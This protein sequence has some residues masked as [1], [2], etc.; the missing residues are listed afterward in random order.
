VGGVQ[1]NWHVGDL[2]IDGDPLAAIAGLPF[3][4]EVI[5]LT[6]TTAELNAE[7]AALVERE[8]R[9]ATRHPERGCDLKW[10][11]DHI[12]M[13]PEGTLS[14][15]NCP[16]YAAPE[17]GVPRRYV[18]ALG[19]EQQAVIEHVRAVVV[20][21]SLEAELAAAVLPEIEACAELAEAH[22]VMA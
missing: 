22:L 20:A 1:A 14:C 4:G 8:N 21:D 9:H 3:G 2:G 13:S 15:H 18:C 19:R 12:L 6:K 17:S 16:L 7:L 5:D 10:G 11:E